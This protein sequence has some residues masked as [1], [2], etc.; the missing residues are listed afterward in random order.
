MSLILIDPPQREPISVL[1]MCVF[2]KIPPEDQEENLIKNL[3]RTAR[4]AVEAYTARSL[5]RQSWRLQTGLAYGLSLS[6]NVYLSGHK[7][8]GLKG[9]ELPR[10][11]FIQLIGKPKF[12]DN[13]N[14]RD[15]STY[16][17]DTA[18]RVAKMHFG[19]LP[20]DQYGS[21]QIDF[22]AGYG[23]QPEEVPEPIRHAVLMMAAELYE[24][25]LGCNDNHGLSPALNQGVI[26][27]IKPYRALR[28]S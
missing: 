25:R 1:E 17:L 7:S 20:A 9:L 15:L 6:D 26:M 3:I 28:L 18:G 27:L 14:A 21:L 10:S 23:D 19:D 16:R 4:Q 22:V 11:P 2:L 12:V 5:I 24:S 8:R 13:G